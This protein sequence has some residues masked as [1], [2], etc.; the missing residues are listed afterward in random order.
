MEF[1]RT[2]PYTR[3]EKPRLVIDHYLDTAALPAPPAVV[4]RASKVTSW[5]MYGNDSIGDCTC[6][7]VGHEIQAW[8]AYA[9]TEATIP[10]SAVIQAY[11]A[12]SGYDPATGA[13]D[14][15]ANVQD[16]LSYWRKTGVGGH[17]IAGFAE[18]G[19]ID[20]LTLAKQCLEI[21]GTVYLGINVPQ[22]AMDQFHAGEPWTY[23]GDQNIIGGH[24]IPVQKWETDV[25]GEIEVVTWGQRQRMTRRFWHNYVEEAWVVF[26]PDWLEAN[27]G[28]PSF[29]NID[30]IRLAFTDLTGDPASF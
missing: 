2:K 6:A 4:D 15:G 27:G 14:N 21:F 8:T 24:A 13:N 20:N 26:S 12:V 18:L 25:L 7:T 10:E 5:P 16:V 19:G 11:S 3:A 28:T 29:Y 23:T 30:Q 9:G 22:S 17:K 1:G